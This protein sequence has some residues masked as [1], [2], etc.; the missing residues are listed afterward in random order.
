MNKIRLPLLALGLGL[1][2]STTL[3]AQ[4]TSNIRRG[5]TFGILP[6]VAYD[7]DLGFQYGALTN[8]EMAR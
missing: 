3:S 5:W 4:D 6:S 1:F 7:A 8:K 2:V